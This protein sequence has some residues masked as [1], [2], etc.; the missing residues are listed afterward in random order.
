MTLKD[1]YKKAKERGAEVVHRDDG[2]Y[3]LKYP[4]G[5]NGNKNPKVLNELGRTTHGR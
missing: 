3:R 5:Y 1:L 2:N 4:V